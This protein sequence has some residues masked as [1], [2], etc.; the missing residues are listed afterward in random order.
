M[1]DYA[2]LYKRRYEKMS[3]DE[4]LKEIKRVLKKDVKPMAMLAAIIIIV[5]S[6]P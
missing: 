3:P 5:N 2:K 4:R 1:Q 6:R